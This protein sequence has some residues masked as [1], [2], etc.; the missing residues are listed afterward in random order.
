MLDKWYK[1][2]QMKIALITGGLGF[3][4]TNLAANLLKT[5][6]LKNVFY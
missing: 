1:N 4:G 2:Y 3:I 5:K 6:K